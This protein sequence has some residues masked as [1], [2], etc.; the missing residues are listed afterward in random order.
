MPSEFRTR[1]TKLFLTF[2]QSGTVTK[3]LL[4]SNAKVLF[5]DNL[6]ACVIAA[7][8]H[9]DGTPHLHAFFD[10]KISKNYTGQQF[11][12]LTG[13]RGNY[14]HARSV[15]QV[16]KYISKADP[17]PLVEGMDLEEYMEA[18]KGKKSKVMTLIAQ[19]VQG[20]SGFREVLQEY[21]GAALQHKRKIEDLVGWVSREKVKSQKLDWTA[22][23]KI[24]IEK[25]FRTIEDRIIYDWLRRNVRREGGM[26]PRAKQLWIFSEETAMGKTTLVENLKKYLNLYYLP[27]DEDFFCT[28]EDGQYDLAVM[29]EF[30]GDWKIARLNQWLGGAVGSY[31][32]KGMD[33]VM[34]TQNIPTIIIGNYPPWKIYSKL[35]KSNPMIFGTL[36]SRLQVVE[37]EEP[38]DLFGGPEVVDDYDYEAMAKLYMSSKAPV[39]DSDSDEESQ[40]TVSY[41]RESAAEILSRLEQPATPLWPAQHETTVSGFGICDIQDDPEGGNSQELELLEHLNGE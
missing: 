16:L 1:S 29:D 23:L 35:A 21:P 5:G 39:E 6:A 37:L 2:P 4:L 10:L 18:A 3:E 25:H 27:R 40:V 38:I 34:K 9:R 15:A 24:D 30:K 26:P 32:R 8:D 22:A 28:W 33:P 19:D 36:E 13:K 17:N 41:R 20:G 31:K 11:D 12:K 7:E 14:Q